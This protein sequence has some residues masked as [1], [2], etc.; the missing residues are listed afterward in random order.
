LY[1]AKKATIALQRE[2]LTLGD[3]YG[4][5]LKCYSSTK[6]INSGLAEDICKAMDTRGLVLKNNPI[7]LAGK[8][9]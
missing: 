5:W 4:I 8:F 7:F 2:T 6:T 3:F 1:P 9:I